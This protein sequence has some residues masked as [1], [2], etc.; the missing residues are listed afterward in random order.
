[1]VRPDTEKMAAIISKHIQGREVSALYLVGGTCCLGDMET[2]I[3][4]YTGVPTFKPANPF[5]V[6]PLGVPQLHRLDRC[7]RLLRIEN[8]HSQ[9]I[10][11]DR[12][13]AYARGTEHTYYRRGAGRAG[14]D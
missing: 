10:N 13:T 2:I 4:K 8:T 3:E 9:W 7:T 5:L 1:M 6:T 12:S 14:A 11:T